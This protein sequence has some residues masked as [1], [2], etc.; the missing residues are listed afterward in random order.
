MFAAIECLPDEE[1]IARQNRC[2]EILA[3][4]V[5]QAGGLMLFSRLG[6]YYLTGALGNGVLWLPLDG[7][8]V[9]AVRK[10]AER[11]RLE[12]PCT[13]VASFRS[14]SELEG[15]CAEAGS[16]L[17]PVIAAEM[18]ALPWS[19]AD[20]LQRRLSAVRFV[21]DEQTVLRAR[22]IKSP[23]ELRKMRFCGARHHESLY[24]IL[25]GMLRPG[26]SEREISH[27]AWR[28]FFEQGH[29]GV[30]RMG[31]YG[32]EVFLGH[33][34]A[35][36]NGNYPS[37]YNGPL[38][39]CGEHPAVPF[40][41]GADTWRMHEML[42]LDLGFGF[43]GYHTDKTQMY[44]S[45]PPSS[46]PDRVR[47]AY[48]LCVEIQERAAWEL[49][50]GALPSAIWKTAQT[51]ARDAGFDEGFMGLGG[52][53]VY[54]LGHGVGLVVDEQPV[55]AEGWDEPLEEGMTIALEPKIGL[56]GI[57][58]VGVE[59]TF[60][61]TVSGGVCLTGNDFSAAYVD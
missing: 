52:N 7:E 3:Q 33:T 28:V 53:K 40:M 4:R 6:L 60:E 44:W 24:G 48:E 14:Y 50:P 39:L 30:L 41:G 56:P 58:M 49:R 61:V 15:L 22:R 2:R 10:G 19:F 20:L 47:R 12:S 21:S 57:G 11:C 5:P 34:A 26:M 25:P 54:F 27:L 17:S 42:M 45:G 8:P 9:M 32:E 55:L 43:E 31:N 51:R 1:R 37:H 59:N 35:G 46:M 23:W 16:K 36:E 38:G 29:C 18:T 13:R